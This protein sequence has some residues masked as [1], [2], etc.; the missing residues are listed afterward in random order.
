MR[1][2]RYIK[3]KIRVRAITPKVKTEIKREFLKEKYNQGA[4]MS[5]KKNS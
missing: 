3:N 1:K 5:G 4:N 2:K